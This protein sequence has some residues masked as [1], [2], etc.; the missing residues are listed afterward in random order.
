MTTE[1]EG[2]VRSL[3]F[4]KFQKHFTNYSEVKMTLGKE[5]AQ[6][7]FKRSDLVHVA[8]TSPLQISIEMTKEIWKQEGKSV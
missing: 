2:F 6:P 3:E 1:E 5:N 7:N 8:Q 4:Q